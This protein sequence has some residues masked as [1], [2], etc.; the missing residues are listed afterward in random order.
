[1]G[2]AGSTGKNIR[3]GGGIIKG[4]G[5]PKSHIEAIETVEEITASGD[6]PLNVPGATRRSNLGIHGAI[7]YNLG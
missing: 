7:R 4:S 3:N 2:E 6:A 5:F 1:V